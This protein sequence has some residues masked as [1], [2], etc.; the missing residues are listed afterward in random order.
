MQKQWIREYIICNIILKYKAVI[1]I[2]VGTQVKSIYIL[3]PF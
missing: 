2:Y 3:S 1:Y